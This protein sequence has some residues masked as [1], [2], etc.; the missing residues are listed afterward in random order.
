ME[1]KQSINEVGMYETIQERG[2]YYANGYKFEVEPIRFEEESSYFRDVPLS[3]YLQNPE[4]EDREEITEQ[5]LARLIASLFQSNSE[6]EVEASL[7]KYGR[8]KLWLVKLTSKRYKYYSDNPSVIGLIK[9]LERKVKYKHK[10]IRFYDLERK[11]KLTKREI[12]GLFLY[13]HNLSG[14]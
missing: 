11:Y 1:E 5:Y 3:I 12:A 7:G 6:E 14:F 4:K 2:S 10:H 9:W 13:M 8:L